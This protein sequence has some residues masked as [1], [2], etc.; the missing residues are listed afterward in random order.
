MLIRLG[1]R[2]SR[3]ALTQA[4]LAA[5]ALRAASAD[6]GEG[7]LTRVEHEML[8]STHGRRVELSSVLNSEPPDLVG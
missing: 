2:G 7:P 8:D 1:S 5:D 3:L 4:E 6:V